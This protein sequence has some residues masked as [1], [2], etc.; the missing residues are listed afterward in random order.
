MKKM[1][2]VLTFL[3]IAVG[4]SAGHDFRA[5]TFSKE[6]MCIEK[7]DSDKDKICYGMARTDVEKILGA[8]Q[9]GGLKNIEYDAGVSIFYRN[10]VVAGLSLEIGS[11][12]KYMTSR[13]A[14]IGM[15]KA[16]IKK[17]Y[18]EK[19]AVENGERN[20]DY[21]YDSADNKFL[22]QVSIGNKQTPEQMVSTY[23]FSVIFDSTAV[24][25]DRIM[26]LDKRMAIYFQ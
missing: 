22:D 15:T 25:A 6:D 14:E 5:D 10:D 7:S 18:G 3:L 13:G 2:A 1:L 16:D 9:Q 26:L 20:L 8:G 23:I 24:S 19:Y 21:F 4:C 11:K 17:I 12:G